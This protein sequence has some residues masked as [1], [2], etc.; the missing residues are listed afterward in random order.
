[1]STEGLSPPPNESS[2]PE[3]SADLRYVIVPENLR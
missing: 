3:G 2:W 1:M